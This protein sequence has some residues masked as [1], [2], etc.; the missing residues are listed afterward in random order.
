M[1]KAVLVIDMPKC[2][3]DCSQYQV[4]PWFGGSCTQVKEEDGWNKPID[5]DDEY[6][7]QSWCPLKPLLEKRYPNDDSYYDYG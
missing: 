1:P 6:S 2:C 4:D 3:K 7:V 5:A